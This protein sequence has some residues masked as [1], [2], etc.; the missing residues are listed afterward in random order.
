MRASLSLL[1]ATWNNVYLDQAE[2]WV[3]TVQTQYADKKDGGYFLST[4]DANDLII[5]SKTI[6][7]NAVPSGN[8]VMAEC[9]ARLYLLT[10]NGVYHKLANTLI[11]TF[12]NSHARNMISQS[13]LMMNFEILER[14]LSIVIISVDKE[15]VGAAIEVSPP[16][17]VILHIPLGATLA[18]NHPTYG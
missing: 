17:R 9:L 15:L 11:C 8:G 10:G 6:A 2:A 3:A 12:S 14:A 13:G 1:E 5:R 4:D 16:W 18:G 7:D